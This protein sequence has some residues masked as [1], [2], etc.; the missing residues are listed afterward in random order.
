MVKRVLA[1]KNLG[2]LDL[3]LAPPA[4]PAKRS[5]SS[6][7][8][9]GPPPETP[10]SPHDDAELC[11]GESSKP[12]LSAAG[13]RLQKKR[14]LGD[15]SAG[16]SSSSNGRDQNSLARLGASGDRRGGAGGSGA[17]SFAADAKHR[18]ADKE[19]GGGGSGTHCG[20]RGWLQEEDDRLREVREDK[21]TLDRT[22]VT[23]VDRDFV[24]F[25]VYGIPL[26][27]MHSIGI[28]HSTASKKRT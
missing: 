3:S 28:Q 8:S 6:S 4:L 11:K 26:D 14:K 7:A 20:R 24:G 17:S 10:T 25:T 15:D 13:D 16:G 23:G 12:F 1:E 27:T 5:S 18:G 19:A 21:W 2:K 9:F 22:T